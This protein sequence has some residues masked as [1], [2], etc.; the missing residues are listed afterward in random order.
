[1][2][3]SGIC[4]KSMFDLILAKH[5]LTLNDSPIGSCFKHPVP[6]LW[7][8]FTNS[9]LAIW[10]R[11]LG[12]DHWQFLLLISC[13]E[14]YL[15]KHLKDRWTLAL[16]T[17]TLSLHTSSNSTWKCLHRCL[18]LKWCSFCQVSTIRYYSLHLVLVLSF[19]FWSVPH[20]QLLVLWHTHTHIGMCVHIHIYAYY[21]YNYMPQMSCFHFHT[22]MLSPTWQTQISK[23]WVWINLYFLSCSSEALCHSNAK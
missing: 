10:S 18:S 20:E 6:S 14:K 1:M 7:G 12:I 2:G 9:G 19:A 8:C 23:T 21:I 22:F 4:N 5:G 13:C 16:P 17:F 3:F 15:K 11:L